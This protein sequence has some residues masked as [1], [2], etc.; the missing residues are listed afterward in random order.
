MAK[1]SRSWDMKGLTQAYEA[2]TGEALSRQ[3]VARYLREGILP[4][5]DEGGN[6]NEHHLERLRMI[7]YLRSRYGMSLRD[8]SGLF[9][10]IEQTREETPGE[11]SEEGVQVTDRRDRI[12]ANATRLFAAK[13]YHGTTIDEIVQATGIAKGTFY[14][15]FD[16]K[17]EL[18]VEVIKRLIDDTLKRIDRALEERDEKDFVARIEAKGREMLDLYLHQSELLYMLLGETVGNPRLMAQLREVYEQLAEGIE[19]DLRLGVEAGGIFPFAD[20]KTI[21][22]ALVGMGQSIA[23]LLMDADEKQVEKTRMAVHE[24]VSRAFSSSREP[25]QRGGRKDGGSRA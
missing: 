21:S 23:I 7:G 17:E 2:E 10:V 19:E 14:I 9:G 13:G 20:L 15:Y 8:I 24:F 12:I 11:E 4:P 1:D 18:L 16:S 25:A 6:F 22:Y 3:Q 5:P